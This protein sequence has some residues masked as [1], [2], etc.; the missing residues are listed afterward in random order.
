MT[1]LSQS[2]HTCGREENSKLEFLLWHLIPGMGFETD[3]EFNVF[4]HLFILLTV[5]TFSKKKTYTYFTILNRR[6]VIIK[7]IVRNFLKNVINV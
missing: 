4:L 2:E 3:Q 7:S 5:Q 1:G 6:T